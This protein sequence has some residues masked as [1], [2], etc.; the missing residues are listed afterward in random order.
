MN[1]KT[2]KEAIKKRY[3]EWAGNLSGVKYRIGDCAY[4]V[5]DTFS[6]GGRQCYRRNG[7]GPDRLYCKQHAK[8]IAEK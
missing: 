1:P 6:W 8:K 7:H 3:G 2:L 5:W 4:E